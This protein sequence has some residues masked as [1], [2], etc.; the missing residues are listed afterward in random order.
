MT[1]GYDALTE[2]EK[3]TLRLMVRGHDAKSMARELSLSVHTTNDRLRAARRKLG[4]T[5]SREA[6]RLAFEREGGTPKNL[7]DK[8][9]GSAGQGGA[10]DNH[11]EPE[12]IRP[13]RKRM[14]LIGGVLMTLILAT[15]LLASQASAPVAPSSMPAPAEAPSAPAARSDAEL[16]QAARTWLELVDRSDWQAS[17]DAAGKSF[18]DVNTV[19]GWQNASVEVRAPLGAVQ[20]REL[21]EVKYV[22]A[23]PSGYRS[24]AF[25]TTFS[26][27]E[28]V[29]VVTLE[30]EADGWR[31]VG[32]IIE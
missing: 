29:E 32:Y 20:S 10:A 12:G 2:K 28:M 4:V 9:L 24:L 16:E 25:F 26:G 13:G 22:N 18:R 1:E 7:A 11:R 6:A 15:F 17:F 3:E 21:V 23:P 27:G 19:E 30:R 31:V 8:E 5:S 14:I